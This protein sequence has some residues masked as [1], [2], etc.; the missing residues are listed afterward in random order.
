M[1]KNKD[2]A[3]I[4]GLMEGDMKE[5]GFKEN[6]MEMESIILKIIQ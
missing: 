6:N 3:Y 5:S 4:I 1:I 2:L